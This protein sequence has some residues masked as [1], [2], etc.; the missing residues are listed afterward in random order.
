MISPLSLAPA[1]SGGEA[2]SNKCSEQREILACQYNLP[3]DKYQQYNPWLHHAIYETRE[4]L[5]FIAVEEMR[6][7]GAYIGIL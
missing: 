6:F 5:W 4:Q 7:W 2:V 1:C 3:R